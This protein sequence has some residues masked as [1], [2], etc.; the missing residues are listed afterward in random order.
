MQEKLPDEERF[1]LQS[2]LKRAAVSIPCNIAEG[3]GRNTTKNYA[4]FLRTSRGSLY[5]L[6]SLITITKELGMISDEDYKNMSDS[7]TEEAKMMNS[8]IK[9]VSTD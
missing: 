7:L 1:G 3:Y 4:Q 9:A 2:Q 8:F 6:E 5:E